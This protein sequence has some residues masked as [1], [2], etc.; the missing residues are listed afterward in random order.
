[1]NTLEAYFIDGLDVNEIA[2]KGDLT[3]EEVVDSLREA[4]VG[5][6]HGSTLDS[7]TAALKAQG[8]MSFHRFVLHSGALNPIKYQARQIGVSRHVLAKFYDAYR[9]FLAD[10]PAGE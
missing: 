5:V 10:H 8:F 9:G 2:K 6:P 3:V 1:M 7:V 4:G